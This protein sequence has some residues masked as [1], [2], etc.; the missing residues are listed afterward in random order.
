MAEYNQFTL[1][2]VDD[3]DDLRDAIAYDFKRRGFQVLTAANG[4]EAFELI[5]SQEVHLVISDIRMPG[6][7]G[8]A[9]LEN[10][11]AHDPEGP[12]VI[13]LT[14]FADV[15]EAECLALGARKVLPKPFDRKTLLQAALE[16]LG[17]S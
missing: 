16:V 14:G 12:P 10:S 13:F 17:I 5:K 7:D 15:T 2:V 4:R 11:K 1:L 6:G 3:E 8:L 9:L